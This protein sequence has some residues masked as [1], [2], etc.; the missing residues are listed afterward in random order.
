MIARPELLPAARDLRENE[1]SAERKLGRGVRERRLEGFRFR[2]QV[3]LLGYV[4]DFASVEVRLIVE[5]DG[6]LPSYMRETP[7]ASTAT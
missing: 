3:P 4:V 1:T 7:C 2:R 6:A 5:V